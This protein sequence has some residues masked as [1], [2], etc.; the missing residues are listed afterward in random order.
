[1]SGTATAFADQ[2]KATSIAEHGLVVRI[3]SVLN[4]Q[5]VSGHIS[6][7]VFVRDRRS[8]VPFSLRRRNAVI[9][10]QGLDVRPLVHLS[11]LAAIIVGQNPSVLRVPQGVCQPLVVIDSE[12][13]LVEVVAL[14]VVGRV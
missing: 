13:V 5:P 11:D 1:M 7:S 14:D 12:A 10:L 3:R 9:H 4:A 2:D 8:P 6:N